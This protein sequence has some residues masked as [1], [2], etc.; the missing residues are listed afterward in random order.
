MRTGPPEGARPLAV[1]PFALRRT[2]E[3][4][5]DFER[6][7]DQ[8]LLA[9]TM[10]RF[11]AEQAPISPYVRDRLDS[12]RGTTAEV[13]AALGDLGVIGLLAPESQAG[14]GMGMVDAAV[15]LEAMGAAVHPGPYLSSA[16]GAISLITLA[17]SDQDRED[18][19]PGLAT[20]TP[21]APS[22]CGSPAGGRGGPS[23]RRPRPVTV[24]GGGSTG[25]RSTS[26]TR[27]ARTS[28][29]SSPVTPTVGAACSP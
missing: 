20:G 21:S 10:R 6:S 13:W 18:L 1:S 29:S 4:Q 3:E 27:S 14:A 11:L 24:T 25:R 5:L 12:D 16:V 9:E 23:R 17:G 7:A 26:P 8:E 28:S 15:V 2:S 19:L 22:R